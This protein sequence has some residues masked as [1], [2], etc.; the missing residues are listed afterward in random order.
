MFEYGFCPIWPT[1]W[2]PMV[3][4]H[5]WRLTYHLSPDFFMHELLLS[6][7]KFCPMDDNKMAANMAAPCRFA[8]VDTLIWLFITQF[9]SNYMHGL[10]SSNFPKLN[11]G[12]CRMNDNQVGCTNGNCLSVCTCGHSNLVI[13]HQISSKFHIWTTFIKLLFISE[14]GFCPMK[15]NQDCRAKVM[16]LFTVGHFAWALCRSLTVLVKIVIFCLSTSHLLINTCKVLSST[17][18]H[19]V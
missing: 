10:L 6:N 9:L 7:H 1:K 14:Y 18:S 19:S 17:K 13:Y 2:L 8:L 11:F 16:F 5:L 15:D 12:Y 3:C 4:L